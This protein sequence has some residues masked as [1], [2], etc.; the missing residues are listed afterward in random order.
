[1]AD[2]RTNEYYNDES[3]KCYRYDKNDNHRRGHSR[4]STPDKSACYNN[5][6]HCYTE[7]RCCKSPRKCKCID[8]Y[9]NDC[10]KNKSSKCC[11]KICKKNYKY[12]A[13]NKIKLFEES[14][15]NGKNEKIFFIT[16]G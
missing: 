11:S 10:E 7:S 1:M 9:N 8:N 13:C 16:I 4:S 15:F 6:C 14:S 2:C 12:D 5:V 3:S